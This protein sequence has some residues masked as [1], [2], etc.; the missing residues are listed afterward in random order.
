[1]TQHRISLYCV[2]ASLVD[3]KAEMRIALLAPFEES[4]PPLMYGGTERVIY[5][6]AE[7]LVK[8]GHHVTLLASG[9]SQTSARLFPCVDESIRSVLENNPRTWHY[10]QWQGFHRAL[11]HLQ[12][13]HYDIV[14]N[15][16]DWPF[17]IADHFT[18]A[19][20]ITTIHNPAQYKLGVPSVYNQYDYVSISDAERR[21][22]PRL[23]YVATVHHGIDPSM[24]EY[25][26]QGGD[27]LVFLGRMSPD[28]GP[29]Q[30]IEI[31]KRTNHKLI[32]AAKID[33]PD[34]HYY[35]QVIKP[36]IDG[37][38]INYIG[39]AAHNTKVTL[40]KNAKALLSPI[41]WDEPFGLTNIE[42]M[43]CGT[44][45]IAI[46]RGA[47]PE[48][49]IDGKTG[50]LCKTIKQMAD[51]VADIDKISRKDC[52]THIEQHF[53]EDRM[54]RDYVRVYQQVIAA[55]TPATTPKARV[56]R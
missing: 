7:G 9:D 27:Y 12:S 21:Y 38:Q 18:A 30:A 40:L 41:Q 51:R 43:A 26:E 55:Q 49:I 35:R 32:M 13:H 6:L 48:I 52:R 1:L 4:V 53:S 10:L 34:R 2:G 28:K 3:R 23:N 56:A 14:H 19:P 33:P 50:Y 31:A 17:L 24:F 15:H 8:L 44:P 37:K 25:N 39:E 5:S 20:M 42:A 36:L 29:T 11:Q 16:G 22:M 45:V 54:A 47:L 46:G